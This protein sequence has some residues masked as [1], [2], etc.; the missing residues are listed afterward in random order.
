MR[1]ARGAS[2]AGLVVLVSSCSGATP[3]EQ[4]PF[5]WN[6]G[7]YA[8]SGSYSWRNDTPQAERTERRSISGRVVVGPDGPTS[9]ETPMGRCIAPSAGRQRDDERVGTRSFSCGDALLTV[10]RQRSNVGVSARVAV[11]VS[12]RRR[13]ECAE[14]QVDEFGKRVCVRY[15]YVLDAHPGSASA[16]IRSVVRQEAGA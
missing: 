1:I 13:G 16:T 14:F 3:A 10:R 15:L 7:R 5:P 2:F 11:Q 6:P 12:V 8:F 9:L 4:N